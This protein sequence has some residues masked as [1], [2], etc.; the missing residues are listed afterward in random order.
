MFFVDYRNDE[1]EDISNG[2]DILLRRYADFI[3]KES[4]DLKIVRLQPS[5]SMVE[6]TRIWERL[7]ETS[8][9]PDLEFDY[10]AVIQRPDEDMSF[11]R[12]CLGHMRVI[13]DT[14]V[15]TFETS[16]VDLDSVVVK[17][18]HAFVTV[19]KRK[20]SCFETCEEQVKPF[21]FTICVLR[22]KNGCDVCKTTMDTGTLRLSFVRPEISARHIHPIQL[23]WLSGRKT[24][25][26]PKKGQDLKI[27]KQS[28]DVLVIHADFLPAFEIT[29]PNTTG[30][31]ILG[32]RSEHH[33]FL[34]PKH[35]KQ[36]A[37]CWRISYCISEIEILQNT[38]Q[39]HREVYKLLKVFQLLFKSGLKS[40][41]IKTALLHHINT[42]RND[43]EGRHI[44]LQ[45][46]LDFMVNGMAN[47]SMPHTI[48]GLNL[49]DVFSEH[50][51]Y[52]YQAQLFYVVLNH[53]L[54]SN[55]DRY[56][57]AS[58]KEIKIILD[59][60]VSENGDDLFVVGGHVMDRDELY[61]ELLEEIMKLGEWVSTKRVNEHRVFDFNSEETCTII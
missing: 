48:E 38:T 13:S 20:C 42:C 7:S 34:V 57:N 44:C 40:Y 54:R 27:H 56:I 58:K 10:L 19:V 4:P 16:S 39:G 12:S 8:R 9:H 49:R 30:N 31:E 55:E 21:A 33:C 18:W 2:V 17:F 51:L 24:L 11:E 22:N 32:K 36:H 28:L 29:V 3:T 50:S 25:M 1:I 37:E 6:R 53:A 43:K 60:F 26:S 14:D 52:L 15:D 45:K 59:A 23:E 41:H 46:T 35:C 61:G 5:G 47:R